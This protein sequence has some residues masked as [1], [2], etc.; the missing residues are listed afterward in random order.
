[1]T[2]QM[3]TAVAKPKV[4]TLT[5]KMYALIMH[6]DDYTT[7][8]FVVDVLISVLSMHEQLAYDAMLTIHHQGY[9]KVATLPKE[10]AEA[11]ATQIHALAER[12]EFPLRVTV[13]PC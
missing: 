2:Q 4:Q 7:M 13:E 12:H 1:M 10:I 5:P 8:E 6:N 11:K 3:P 9:A